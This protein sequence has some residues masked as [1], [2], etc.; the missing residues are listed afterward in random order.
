VDNWSSAIIEM[1]AIFGGL[2]VILMGAIEIHSGVL[3]SEL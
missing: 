1:V 3:T 2:A